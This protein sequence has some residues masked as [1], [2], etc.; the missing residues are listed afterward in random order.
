M[1][2]YPKQ[3]KYMCEITVDPAKWV[4]DEMGVKPDRSELMDDI[5][6]GLLPF[7]MGMME[8]AKAG[9]YITSMQLSGADKPIIGRMG[10]IIRRTENEQR[11]EN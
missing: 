2:K 3:L 5:D 7:I 4:K 9:G 1:G 11:R 10:K 6:S 8:V